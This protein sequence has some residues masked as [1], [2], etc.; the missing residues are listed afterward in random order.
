[1]IRVLRVLRRWCFALV[2]RHAYDTL[3]IHPGLIQ[4]ACW[5]G[6]TSSGISEAPRRPLRVWTAKLLRFR[7]R[8]AKG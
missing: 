2:H 3:L 1:M 5:C 6:K 4:V 7:R 8:L